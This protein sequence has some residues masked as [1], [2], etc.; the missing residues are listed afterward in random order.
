M[1][2]IQ[3]GAGA[4]DQDPRRNY[5]DGFSEFVKKNDVIEKKIV[6]VE[7]NPNNIKKL[8][9]SWESFN[10][11]KIINSA[12]VPDNIN[13]KFLDFY[14]CEEDAP[15]YQ[16]FSY[17]L[18]HVKKHFPKAKQINSIKI[19]TQK[20]SDF[21]IS[22]FKDSKIDYLGIDLEG[23]DFEIVRDLDLTKFDILNISFEFLHMSFNQK[24]KIINKLNDNGY[25]YCGYGFDNENCDWIFTKKKLFLNQIISN[26][27]PYISHKHIKFLNKLISKNY[28][29]KL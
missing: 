15:H 14:Y 10:N 2:F 22:E 28:L 25:S 27:L 13:S 21:L 7:A 9:Q 29:F 4:G 11:T 23:I 1:I 5:R 17:K 3:L 24:R 19:K 16:T 12:I 20:I 26:F 18:E 8:K 6:L